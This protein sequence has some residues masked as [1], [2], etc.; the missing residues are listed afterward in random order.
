MKKIIRLPSMSRVQPGSKAT[1]Q[2]PLGP[3]YERIVFNVAAGAGLDATD[4]GRIDVVMNGNVKMTF[5]DLQRLIDINTYYGRE[6]DT[7]SAT[8]MQ[9]AIHFN[10]AELQDNIWRAA[11]GVGTQDLQ[12]L[13][14]EMD[15]PGTAPAD[16]TIAAFAQA[17]PERQNLGVFFNIKE[18]PVSTSTAGLFE[19]DKLPRGAWYSAIHLFKSDISNVEVVA[20]D[21][22]IVDAPKGTLERFQKAG[23]PRQ[24][25]PL[26]AKATH[27]DFTT[28]GNLLDCLPTANLDDFRIRMTLTTSGNVDI[29]TETLDTLG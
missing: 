4:I 25:V 18:F 20:N 24:R 23:A 26:T 28:D 14:I 7:V 5:K 15:I 12:T 3:T 1:L 13:H 2:I 27:V 11:P 21:V 29:V 16:M 19:A 6:A 17:N 8:A 22:K 10:R 9:F